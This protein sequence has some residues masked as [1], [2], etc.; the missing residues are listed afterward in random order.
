MPY[1]AFI[2]L[3]GKEKTTKEAGKQ[4]SLNTSQYYP[5]II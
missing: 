1:L 2:E 5:T 3:L 4:Q